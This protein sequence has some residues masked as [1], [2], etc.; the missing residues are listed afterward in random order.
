MRLLIVEDET[1]IARGLAFNFEQ[2][3]YAVTLAADGPTALSQFEAASDGGD[4]APF[5]C[6]VLDLM[7]P[8]MSGYAICEQIRS[9]DAEV[10]ILVLSARTLAEDKARAFDSGCDQYLT[11]PFALE[12]LLSR[13]R[14][15]TSRRLP[16]TP[17]EETSD[18]LVLGDRTID[19][20]RHQVVI[21]DTTTAELTKMELALLRYFH[22]QPGVVLSREAISRDVWGQAADVSSRSIDNFVLRLRK[23]LEPD[24]AQPRHLISVRGTGYRFVPNP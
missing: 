7:L 5:D 18:L 14:N 4:A 24:P 8:G 11:K 19:F 21:D 16:R 17:P 15:L 9:R 13:V 20:K 10:P 12:E 6:V 22:R 1:S 23:L 2:E 3:G